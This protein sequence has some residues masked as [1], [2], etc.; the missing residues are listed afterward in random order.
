MRTLA[1]GDIHG[2]RKA[3]ETLVTYAKISPSDTLVT[4]G[5]YVDRGPDSAGVVDWLLQ[6][7]I[8]GHLIPLRG[9]HEI[10]F[11]DARDAPGARP[12]WLRV[13]GKATLASYGIEW[14]PSSPVAFDAIPDEHWTFFEQRCR[15][16]FETEG[17][18]FVHASVDAET[19]MHAQSPTDL[20]WQSIYGAAPHCSGK[21][22]IC[23]HSTQRSGDP[24][25]LG[26]AVCIDTFAYGDGWLT[27]LDVDSGRYWQASETGQTR[28]GTLDG[29]IGR[30]LLRR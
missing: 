23:G 14:S 5:D 3:L 24:L 7:D 26:Y 16:Y 17:H 2:S 12:G 25:D 27:C 18:I 20:Y 15:P 22:V 28:D 21:T 30:S 13:G 10:M 1:I 4:L 29:Q 9:N 11:V 6:W 8:V 19:P